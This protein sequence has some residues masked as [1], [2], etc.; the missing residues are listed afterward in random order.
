MADVLQCDAAFGAA[1]AA[2]REQIAFGSTPQTAL[3][4]A[5]IVYQQRNPRI[6]TEEARTLVADA[7]DLVES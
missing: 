2:Y 7:L 6:P 5:T 4:L 3:D 1:K